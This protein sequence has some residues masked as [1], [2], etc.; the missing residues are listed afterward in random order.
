MHHPLEILMIWKGGLVFYG[1]FLLALFTGVWYLN[2]FNMPLWKVADIIA[3]CI[4]LG[5]AIGRLGCFSA[6]C[7][8]GK[9]T[10]LPWGVTFTDPNSLAV[11]GV[12]LHPTQIYESAGA[13]TIFAFLW[14][15]RKKT[16]FEGQLFWLYVMLYS[17]LR[18][19]IEFVRGDEVR[20]FVNI[21]SFTLSTSQ[22]VAICAFLASVVMMNRLKRAR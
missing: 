19:T 13:L 5:Q 7:R 3:P 22:A 11:L 9:P 1:G 12:P 20:G 21:A 16:T 14:L 4:A 17:V 8:Y 15:Y 2:R 18:F 10:D 6:G